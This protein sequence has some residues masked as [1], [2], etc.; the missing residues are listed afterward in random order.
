MRRSI[1]TASPTVTNSA[2]WRTRS[3]ASNRSK[4]W[5]VLGG[6][7]SALFGSGPP[8]G[9]INVV[10]YDPS[11]IF[12]WGTSTQFNSFGGVTNSEYVTG[13]TGIAGLNYRIDTTVTGG[14]AFR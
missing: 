13:P 11:P 4:Y 7:G 5:K 9:T 1:L 8:G 3:T 14:D 10:H 6:P 2:A 12:H